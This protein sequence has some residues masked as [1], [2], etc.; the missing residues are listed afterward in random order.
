MNKI[1]QLRIEVQKSGVV[2]V[3]IDAY[4]ELQSEWIVRA[5]IDQWVSVSDRLPRDET[6]RVWLNLEETEA[7]A[8]RVKDS[9]GRSRWV[10]SCATFDD[11]ALEISHWQ[12]MCKPPQTD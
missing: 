8:Y 4:N 3:D 7:I 6:V 5:K 2:A 12:S 10:F 1:S 11:C 9:T